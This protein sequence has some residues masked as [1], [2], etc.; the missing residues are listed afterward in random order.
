MEQ[1]RTPLNALRIAVALIQIVHPLHGLWSGGH[2][3]EDIAGF[4]GFLSSV[5]L[6][7]GVALAWLTILVQLA[8]CGALL[9]GRYVVPACLALIGILAAGIVLIHAHEG[10]FVVG[11]GR[12][13]VE[14][15]ALLIACLASLAWASW[16]R[17]SRT[18]STAAAR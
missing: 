16:P 18:R 12:N 1:A 7:F 13:G 6:P 5:G 17:P 15:S 2:L 10:W 11:A 4:G 9:A 8:A 3:G 14:F